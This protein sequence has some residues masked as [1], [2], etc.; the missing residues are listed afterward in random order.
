MIE[1]G[2]QKVTLDTF[3][4]EHMPSLNSDNDSR[5]IL[6]DP[7]GQERRIYL[8]PSRP[9]GAGQAANKVLNAILQLTQKGTWTDSH[10]LTIKLLAAA[11]NEQKVTWETKPGTRSE[12]AASM[13]AAITGVAEGTVFEIDLAPIM[14]AAANNGWLW[15]GIEIRTSSTALAYFFSEKDA[16]GRGPHMRWK[17][18]IEPVKPTRLHPSAA[19]SD[20]KPRFLSETGSVPVESQQIQVATDANFS[21]I[22]RDITQTGLSK[23]RVDY[24]PG[25]EFTALTSNAIY[26]WRNRYTTPDGLTSAWSSGQQFSIKSKIS[27]TL[28]SVITPETNDITPTISWTNVNGEGGAQSKYRITLQE[29]DEKSQKYLSPKKDKK[30]KWSGGYTTGEVKSTSTSFTVPAGVLHTGKKY[31]LTVDV[32]DSALRD[33]ESTDRAFTRVT[34]VFNLLSAGDTAPVDTLTATQTTRDGQ[35]AGT[36]GAPPIVRLS[37]TYG[38][39]ADRFRVLRRIAGNSKWKVLA[40]TAPTEFTAEFAAGY[41]YYDVGVSGKECIYQVQPIVGNKSAQ[42]VS[43][44]PHFTLGTDKW[45]LGVGGGAVAS[46]K[47]IDDVDTESNKALMVVI[48]NGGTALTNVNL[49][50]ALP[51]CGAGKAYKVCLKIR[52]REGTKSVQCAL[53]RNDSPYTAY[54]SDTFTIGSA[55]TTKLWTWTVSEAVTPR[56]YLYIGGDANDV[57]IDY[58]Y[59]EIA[60]IARITP[61]TL[62]AWLITVDDMTLRVPV[63]LNGQV[64]NSI[65]EKREELHPLGGKFVVIRSAGAARKIS[66]SCLIDESEGNYR[67][68]LDA[69]RWLGSDCWLTTSKGDVHRVQ[70][71][72]QSERAIRSG[73]RKLYQLDLDLFE[74]SD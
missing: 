67:A 62:G 2:L 70:L 40:D 49:S 58:F 18:S 54:G 6:G 20:T 33:D 68:R 35:P 16:N 65:E 63:V 48:S 55:W 5:L 64:G 39:S 13:T 37:W 41:E 9:E 21:T 36:S 50:Q 8:M 51:A 30:G 29:W 46:L 15:Y 59:A 38:G 19:R 53:R 57:D 47:V 1:T 60:P 74:V 69:I 24:D 7:V 11:F 23:K 10:T 71:G 72:N 17:W 3:V 45:S 61:S 31:L 14:E 4:N 28:N 26:F 44:N 73:S 34:S 56:L 42:G 66:V 25:A 52:S 22:I 43:Y 27:V 12:G 32:W